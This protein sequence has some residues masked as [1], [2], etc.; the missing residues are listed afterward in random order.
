MLDRQKREGIVNAGAA[1]KSIKLIEV[2]RASEPEVKS[3]VFSQ[4]SQLEE[5]GGADEDVVDFSSQ[6]YRGCSHGG[7]HRRLSVRLSLPSSPFSPADSMQ[8]RRFDDPITSRVHHQRVLQAAQTERPEGHRQEPGE[9]QSAQWSRFAWSA[10]GDAHLPQGTLPRGKG[11]ELTSC[12]GRRVRS[13]LDVRVAGVPH[14]S[15]V[16]GVRRASFSSSA[17][18]TVTLDLSRS[19]LLIESTVSDRRARESPPRRL[20]RPD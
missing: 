10:D 1:A 4:V 9:R 16:A 12:A 17:L 15:V 11:R 13:Q 8:I 6:L 18:L 5:R 14:G 20:I 19:K 2:L 7:R 3:L